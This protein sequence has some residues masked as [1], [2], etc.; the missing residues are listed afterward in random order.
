ML[1]V[2]PTRGGGS[3]PLR[4]NKT[5]RE[6]LR[7]LLREAGERLAAVSAAEIDASLAGALDSLGAGGCEREAL[8]R[9]SFLRQ[10]SSFRP[11]LR[12]E[13]REVRLVLALARALLQCGELDSAAQHLVAVAQESLEQ[14][15]VSRLQQE[16]AAARERR[17][18]AELEDFA[19]RDAVLTGFAESTAA[20]DIGQCDTAAIERL[21]ST[22]ETVVVRADRQELAAW[23]AEH[24]GVPYIP[25]FFLAKGYQACGDLASSVRSLVRSKKW[26]ET[27]LFGYEREAEALERRLREEQIKS[28]YTG[29]YALV[30]LASHYKRWADLPGV[31]A[32]DRQIEEKLRKIGFDGVDVVRDPTKRELERTVQRFIAAHGTGAGNRNRLLIYYA[33][34]GETLTPQYGKTAVPLGFLIPVDAARKPAPG[35][36]ADDFIDSAVSMDQVESWARQIESLH[37]MFVF[38]SCYSGTIFWAISRTRGGL[39][40]VVV[41]EAVR[42][43]VRLFITAGNDKQQVPDSSVFLK[44]LLAAL[45]WEEDADSSRDGFLSGGELCLFLKERVTPANGGV[46]PQCGTMP[47]PYNRGDLIFVRPQERGAQ[48]RGA[49]P[50]ARTSPEALMADLSSWKAAAAS[51]A[52]ESYRRYLELHPKGRFAGPARYRLLRLERLRPQ[53]DGTRRESSARLSRTLIF[54]T[55]SGPIPGFLPEMGPRFP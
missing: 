5:L 9:L 1:L 14:G 2:R 36:P 30:L 4:S 39:L 3:A 26:Q 19:A 50:P 41:D 12:T 31:E 8:A 54:G 7:E 47:P 43:P 16:L 46:T 40:P 23:I 11:D 6:R 22:T 53:E 37:A 45:T 28:F 49:E 35:E 25:Q 21:R 42:E 48:Q 51:G 13:E 15:E 24:A 33:G 27:P 20:I 52:A 44:S 17:L 55:S 29:S 18:R 38:N 32:E 10:F 34:H